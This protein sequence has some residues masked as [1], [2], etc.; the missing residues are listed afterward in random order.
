MPRVDSLVLNKYLRQT[1]SGENGNY[2]IPFVNNKIVSYRLLHV[3]NN[4]TKSRYNK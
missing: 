3:Y 1:N 2:L 4:F